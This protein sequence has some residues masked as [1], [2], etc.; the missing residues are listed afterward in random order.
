MD[1]DYKAIVGKMPVKARYECEKGFIMH[2]TIHGDWGW[3]RKDGSFE[4]PRCEKPEEWKELEF[5]LHN[6]REGRFKDKDGRVFAGM[7][8]ARTKTKTR[9]VGEWEYGCN[10]GFNYHAAGAI[11]RTLGF[12]NG[13]QT[14]LTRRMQIMEDSEAAVP[15]FGWTGFNCKHGDTLPSSA[16]CRAQRYEDAM[17]ERG[18]KAKCFNFDRIAVKCFD[19]AQFNV[20]VSLTFSNRVISCRAAAHKEGY[21]LNMGQMDGVK[22]IFKMDDKDI[23]GV[24][25]YRMKRG[26]FQK[27][28][29]LK[30]QSFKCLSCEVHA[31]DMMIGKAERCRDADEQ[32][33][34]VE[35]PNGWN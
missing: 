20:T 5:K 16:H 32:K 22:A 34:P 12:K 14:P 19:D 23:P 35:K 10:D 21:R 25:Q 17:K 1:E 6:G 29:N 18:M 33:K 13:A 7:V 4:V 11:C 15:K 9:A 8:L 27:V 30:K 26:Y 28:K 3:C 2:N 31:G 24:K